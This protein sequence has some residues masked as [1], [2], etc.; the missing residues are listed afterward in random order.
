MKHTFKIGDKVRVL[1]KSRGGPLHNSNVYRKCQQQGY[2]YI[3]QINGKHEIV[4]HHDKKIRYDGDFFA[5]KDLEPY[6]EPYIVPEELFE[7]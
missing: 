3:T 7:L 6:I 4:V 1:S 5:P 2:G